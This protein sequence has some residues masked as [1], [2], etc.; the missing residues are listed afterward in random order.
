MFFMMGITDE[1]KELEFSQV[2]VC[3]ACGAYGRYRVYMT[4][5]LLSLFFIPC[6]R[7][8]RRYFVETSCCGTLYMLDAE[9]GRCIARGE[10]VE[11][12]PEHLSPCGQGGAYKRCGNCGYATQE[13]FDFCPKCGKKF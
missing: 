12:R 3:S 11:I 8:N 7:W 4:C 13:D 10:D 2:T 9:V 1:H 6:F 5:T